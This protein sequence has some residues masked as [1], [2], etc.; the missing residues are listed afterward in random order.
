MIKIQQNIIEVER[1]TSF[2]V[3]DG[4]L[5]RL[6]DYELEKVIKN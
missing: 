4:Q 6:F 1:N 2:N 5:K 3:F